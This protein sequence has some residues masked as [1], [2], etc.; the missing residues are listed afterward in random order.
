M[1]FDTQII[2]YDPE[3][4]E[5]NEML[6]ITNE[7]ID[8]LSNARIDTDQIEATYWGNVEVNGQEESVLVVRMKSGTEYNLM[9]SEGVRL[10]ETWRD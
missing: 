1:L 2:T 9:S 10:L 4:A 3:Q 6:G 8:S 7:R 5:R